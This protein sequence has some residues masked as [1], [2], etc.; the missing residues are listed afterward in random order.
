[1]RN[2]TTKSGR[3]NFKVCLQREGRLESCGYL[4]LESQGVVFKSPR[5]IEVMAD[6]IARIE[7]PGPQCCGRSLMIE[8]I[9]IG[10]EECT[11]GC[12]EIT[13][14]FLQDEDFDFEESAVRSEAA[15]VIHLLN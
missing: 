2:L 6:L 9:V 15:A 1:M 12:Y 14:L 3:Q 5:G 13:V 10:C 8:G 7:C 11:D 4:R